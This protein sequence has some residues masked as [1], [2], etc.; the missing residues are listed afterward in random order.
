M[1]DA[2]PSDPASAI[3]PTLAGKLMQK[4]CEFEDANADLQQ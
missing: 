4:R 1:Q 3:P 2:S